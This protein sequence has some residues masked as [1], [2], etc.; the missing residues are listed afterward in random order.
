[1]LPKLIC[2]RMLTTGKSKGP[3][4]LLFSSYHTKVR[5]SS[6]TPS[7]NPDPSDPSK[8][9]IA[10]FNSIKSLLPKSFHS[11]LSLEY[12]CDSTQRTIDIAYINPTED[13]RVAIEYDGPWHW[14]TKRGK[15][16]FERFRDKNCRP[17]KK[18]ETRNLD[19]QSAG[20]L[21]VPIRALPE[22]HNDK[23]IFERLGDLL[24]LVDP[25]TLS[26]KENT[27]KQAFNIRL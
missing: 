16:A 10:Y 22:A 4:A 5:V 25:S 20:W 9:Q 8:G 15:R 3:Q 11:L 2:S 23:V 21:V 26:E 14:A 27:D 7:S 1:M 6:P 17:N 13:L 18:T 19:L 24:P 12:F